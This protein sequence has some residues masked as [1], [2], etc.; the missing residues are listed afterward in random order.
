[1]LNLPGLARVAKDEID[2]MTKKQ[3]DAATAARQLRLKLE[4]DEISAET[5]LKDLLR[6]L[7]NGADKST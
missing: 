1:M 2:A 5:L 6:G 4:N 7:A 3:K